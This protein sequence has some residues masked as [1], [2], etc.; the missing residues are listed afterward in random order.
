MSRWLRV[1]LGIA[2]LIGA[3]AGWAAWRGDGLRHESA[4]SLREVIGPPAP[5]VE[6]TLPAS[7]RIPDATP[8][9]A[10]PPPT[11]RRPPDLRGISFVL[12]LGADNRSDK[13]VG[14]TDAMIVLGFRHRDGKI[15]AF[16]IPRDL[17]IPLPDV[18]DLHEQGRDHARVSSVVRVGEAR[19]GTG[20]GMPLLRRTL[21]EQFGIRIDR[22][23]TIDFR[24]FVALV[25]ELGGVDVDVPC[26]IQDCFWTNGMDQPCVVIDVEPG[27]VHMDGATALSYVR[28]RHGT[29]DHDRTRRQQAVLLA[30]A[31]KARASGLRGLPGLWRLA[32][33]FVE[34]DLEVDDALYYA[35]FA[36]ST[37]LAQIGGFS[38]AHPMTSRFVTDDGKHV[39]LLDREA[40]D[41]A[42]EGMF[43][44]ELPAL[45]E[46]R[47]CR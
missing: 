41:R 46:R 29:G 11:I 15:A 31:A 25:D 42:L 6:W 30:F 23:A 28:S 3:V 10:A 32:A 24:G 13:V 4:R 5:S 26:P 45:R 33:P 12:L 19:L 22:V 43:D 47:R 27:R 34:T 40:F 36:L 8:E 44:G 38:I 14:R 7:T 2:L 17:W 18:G 9:L 39:M 35:S 16:S 20:Q 37:E 1:V 21:S